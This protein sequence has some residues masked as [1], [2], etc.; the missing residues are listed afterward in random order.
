[1]LFDP[2]LIGN[3]QIKNRLVRSA[4]YESMATPEGEY[5]DEL[6]NLY[7]KL[8]K[9][10]VGL[11]IT[12]HMYVQ[13]SGKGGPLQI[14]IHE[15]KMIPGLKKLTHLVKQ[16]DSKIIF[17]L[18]HAGIQKTSKPIAPSKK[19]RHPILFRKPRKMTEGDISETINSFIN[20]SKRSIEAGADGIQLLAS[21]GYLI[22]EFLSP[23]FNDRNDDWGGSAEN[24]FLFLKKIIKGIKQDFPSNKLLLVKLNAHDYL[25]SDSIDPTLSAKYAKWLVELGVDAIEISC[26]S[27][28]FSPFTCARGDVPLKA[29]MKMLPLWMRPFAW[30]KL[31]GMVG[32]YDLDQEGFNL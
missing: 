5:T 15:D 10:N 30:F 27:T 13:T 22:N 12:G 8:A 1:M 3:V 17:Q 28:M 25:P 16:N 2:I 18:S 29:F 19:I 23:Y 9:G 32:K 11:I 20:A 31:K 14:G 21:H 24:R 6:G 7:A 4:T 26:G